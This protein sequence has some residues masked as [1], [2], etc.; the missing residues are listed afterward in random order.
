MVAVLNA[1]V[2]TSSQPEHGGCVGLSDGDEDR[3]CKV[4][5]EEGLQYS[6]LL[7]RPRGQSRPPAPQLRPP[8]SESG[9]QWL[10]LWRVCELTT[11]HERDVNLSPSYTHV[12][13]QAHVATT[14]RTAFQTS[15]IPQ[16]VGHP[17]NSKP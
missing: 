9:G 16:Q 1:P 10:R 17:R 15:V 6:T 4:T 5:P 14:V 13:T 3:S 12:R 7:L 2:C 11:V 8:D